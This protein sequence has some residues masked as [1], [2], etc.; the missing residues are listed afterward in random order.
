MDTGKGT[1]SVGPDNDHLEGHSLLYIT[2]NFPTVIKKILCYEK[3]FAIQ[4]YQRLKL[5]SFLLMSEDVTIKEKRKT[6][7]NTEIM[8]PQILFYEIIISLS[9]FL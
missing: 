2:L 6:S 5:S 3:K 4:T 9:F 8:M 7:L 1:A